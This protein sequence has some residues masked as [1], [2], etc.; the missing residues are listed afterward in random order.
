MPRTMPWTASSPAAPC[1]SKSLKPR[2]KPSSHTM[3]ALPVI[4]HQPVDSIAPLIHANTKHRSSYL[5]LLLLLQQAQTPPPSSPPPPPAPGSSTSAWTTT[6]PATRSSTRSI[7]R[8]AATMGRHSMRRR[9]VASSG[10]TLRGRG[11]GSGA[12]GQGGMWGG[13]RRR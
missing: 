3:H 1:A 7:K 2:Y 12:G 4:R 10:G 9:P 5:L 6:A 11:V 13:C 8:S